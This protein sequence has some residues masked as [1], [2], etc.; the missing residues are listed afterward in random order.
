MFEIMTLSCIYLPLWPEFY[1]TVTKPKQNLH[2]DEMSYSTGQMS[3]FRSS[4]RYIM[5]CRGFS[6]GTDFLV[7]ELY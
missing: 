7:I 4:Q 6:K 1:L 5:R 2:G 3:L